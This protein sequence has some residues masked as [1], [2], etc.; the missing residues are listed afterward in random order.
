MAAW[1]IGPKDVL[2]KDAA[3]TRAVSDLR[4]TRESLMLDWGG[5]K[6]PLQPGIAT[7]G[8]YDGSHRAARERPAHHGADDVLDCARSQWKQ[9][10]FLRAV[11]S[12]ECGHVES[13][14]ARPRDFAARFCQPIGTNVSRR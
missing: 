11:W 4:G 2:W 10:N 12:S 9:R 1:K 14:L 13:E 3:V 6:I 8:L 5:R 7:A